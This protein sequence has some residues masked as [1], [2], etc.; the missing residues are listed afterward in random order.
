M[1]YTTVCH[2]VVYSKIVDIALVDKYR[3]TFLER[4]IKM[5]KDSSNSLSHNHILINIPI[6]SFNCHILLYYH[7]IILYTCTSDISDYN[8]LVTQLMKPQLMKLFL[9]FFC[10]PTY[11]TFFGNFLPF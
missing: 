3:P 2:T 10:P 5:E 9:I 11:E 8:T 1:T 6:N 7:P 4:F